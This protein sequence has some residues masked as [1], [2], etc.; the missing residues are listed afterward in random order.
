MTYLFIVKVT[1]GIVNC[2]SDHIQITG[3]ITIGENIQCTTPQYV[4]KRSK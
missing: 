4:S 1:T 3:F 2:E